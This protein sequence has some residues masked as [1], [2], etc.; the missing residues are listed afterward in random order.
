MRV[1][2]LTTFA[3]FNQSYSL[4]GVVLEQCAML[5]ENGM[6]YAL[7]VN[8]IGPRLNDES[9]DSVD[10]LNV[11]KEMPTASLKEDVIDDDLSERTQK[12]LRGILDDFDVVICHD[13]MFL[14]WNVS[15]NH[16]IRAVADDFPNVTWVHWV[17]SAPGGRP[18]RLLPDSAQLLR[19]TPAPN[20]IYVY[21]NHEDRLRYAESIGVDVGDV[22]VCYNPT[23]MASF[24]GCDEK[25]A[26]F[27]RDFRLWDHDLMQTYPISMTR[28]NEKGLP[29]VIAMFGAWKQL[30]FGVKLVVANAH[31]TAKKEKATV[32][33]YK[34]MG[35]REWGLT[36]HDLIFTSDVEGWEYQA[37]H[38]TV[39]R[40]LQ[41]SNIFLFP[42][43]SEA[44]SRVLQEASLAGC[45]VVG[46]SSFSP[47][48]EFLDPS[49]PK[50][51]FGSLRDER[52]YH[53]SEQQWLREVAKATTPLLNHPLLKQKSH[54][55]RLCSRETIWR[56]Q[57][58]PILER[59]GVPCAV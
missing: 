36:P 55:M 41:L 37:P 20:S 2:I 18:A 40:L 11:R 31:C 56:T 43:V 57:F 39:K 19:Y 47:M 8:E 24:L 52:K 13:L 17:H 50:H 45:L 6:D 14:T 3:D 35:Y 34:E 59:A 46:N 1:A 22:E 49:C 21:L 12:F 26:T 53:P 38:R 10:W 58:L 28:A 5:K 15:Y 7:F 16:A 33:T 48:Y 25:E 9:I 4:V 51:T 54:M 29:K 30:G 32:E 27:I 23:D 42:T 44:C